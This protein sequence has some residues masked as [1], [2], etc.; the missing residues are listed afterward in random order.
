MVATH[1]W[2]INRSS[3][4]G[5]LELAANGILLNFVYI[6]AFFVDDSIKHAVKKPKSSSPNKSIKE[7]RK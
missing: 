1:I 7:I 3:N 4:L 5:D 6:S 2:F